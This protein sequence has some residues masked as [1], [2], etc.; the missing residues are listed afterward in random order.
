M[1]S[2]F[3]IVNDEG[4]KWWPDKGLDNWANSGDRPKLSKYGYRFWRVET[5]EGY[6]SFVVTVDEAIV[7]ENQS[8]TAVAVRIDVWRMLAKDAMWSG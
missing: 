2:K 3:P 7:Y 6:K 8:S 5:K 4:T 1:E